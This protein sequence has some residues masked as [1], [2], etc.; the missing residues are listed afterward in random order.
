MSAKNAGVNIKP[1]KGKC[2]DR[3]CP[4]HGD[5]TVRG[6]TIMGTIARSRAMRTAIVQ[7]TR[8]RPVKKYERTERR[9]TKLKVHN[10]S[11]VDAHE[12]DRV[13]IMET[14]PLSKTKN[15]VILQ[16]FG[17]NVEYM[18]KAQRIE[19]DKAEVEKAEEVEE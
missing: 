19:E 1:P 5:V 11:C 14:R 3:K 2:E 18:A 9:K 7:T 8:H 12:G 15:F 13:L 16:K 17:E 10:P 6:R 4:F